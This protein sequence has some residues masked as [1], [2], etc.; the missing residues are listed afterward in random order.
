[1]SE[2]DKHFSALTNAV[3][4][5]MSVGLADGPV[6]STAQRNA[7]YLNALEFSRKAMA[8]VSPPSPSEHPLA[9]KGE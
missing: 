1:M 7:A 3:E 9:P 8:A 4:I 5:A 2:A 6:G